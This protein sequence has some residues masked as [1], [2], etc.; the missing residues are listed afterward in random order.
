[1]ALVFDVCIF[2]FIVAIIFAQ[3]YTIIKFD[4]RIN[5]LAKEVGV[6]QITGKNQ[7]GMINQRLRKIEKETQRRPRLKNKQPTYMRGELQL[8]RDGQVASCDATFKPTEVR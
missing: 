3:Y 6:R 1:M 2:I 5:N 8:R 4:E 7:R